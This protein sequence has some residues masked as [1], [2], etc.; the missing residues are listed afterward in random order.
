VNINIFKASK[1]ISEKFN[2]MGSGSAFKHQTNS[3]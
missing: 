3:A 2:I 1:L